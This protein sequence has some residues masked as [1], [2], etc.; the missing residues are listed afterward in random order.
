MNCSSPL[1]PARVLLLV[2]NEHFITTSSQ[3]LKT[4]LVT[5]RSPSPSIEISPSLSSL[6]KPASLCFTPSAQRKPAAN[7]VRLP[8]L[9][10]A[11]LQTTSAYTNTTTSLVPPHSPHGLAPHNNPTST[12]RPL[13]PRRP[14]H[15][16][17]EPLPL[18]PGTRLLQ[19]PHPPILPSSRVPALPLAHP[20]RLS[21]NGNAAPTIR[22]RGACAARDGVADC[23]AGGVEADG[24]WWGLGSA[25]GYLDG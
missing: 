18:D 5:T 23:E 21:Q 4:L 8:H 1:A 12:R 7:M 9:P 3:L 15:P 20:T 24:G 16:P 13:R 14:R 6:A 17:H 10:I 2:T 22:D 19:T 25:C 11:H